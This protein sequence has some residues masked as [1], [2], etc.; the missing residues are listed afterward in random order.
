MTKP[1]DI[2]VLGA[3]VDNAVSRS[4]IR[5]TTQRVGHRF[6]ERVLFKRMDLSFM[7]GHS[8]AITG[9]NGSGK[10]TLVRILAGLMQPTKGTVLLSVDGQEIDPE[11]RPLSSGLVAPYLNVYQGFTPRENL[12][13]I[14]QAR[15][16]GRAHPRIQEVLETVQID[17]RADDQVGTFSS[18]MLQR[19]KI[20]CAL[21]PDPPVLF[22]DEPSAT[23]DVDGVAMTRRVIAKAL[24][25]GRIIIVATNEPDEAEACEGK[26]A[27]EDYQ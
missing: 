16:M 7:G 24:E 19:V 22:L 10:S 4:S 18:G 26:I 14:A 21:L 6:G 27:I 1:S 25:D 5:L 9:A 23:L 15:G 3:Q 17:M 2:S 20:A 13:F 8:M 12:Q 11:L